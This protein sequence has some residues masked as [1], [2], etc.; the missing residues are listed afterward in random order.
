VI[1][2]SVCPTPYKGVF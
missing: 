1:C 2:P